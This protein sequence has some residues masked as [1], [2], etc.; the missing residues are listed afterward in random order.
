M[1]GTRNHIKQNKHYSA[2][3]VH[4]F[5]SHVGSGKIRHESRRGTPKVKEG[6]R[7]SGKGYKSGKC[8][9]I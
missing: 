6:M 3:Q 8:G 1:D 2:R 7:G 9:S 5:V 4:V